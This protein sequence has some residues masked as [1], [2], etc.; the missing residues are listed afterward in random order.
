MTIRRI[1]LLAFLL[2]SLLP[3]A[4][5]T[6]LAFDRSRAAMLGEIEQGVMRSTA[7]VSAEADKLLYE[8]LLNATTWNHLE[9]MQDLRIDDVDKRLSSFLSE[10]KLRYG[11][12]Y[13][14]LHAVDGAGR[15]VA[16]SDPARIGQ[17]YPTPHPWAQ[18]ALPGGLVRVEQPSETAGS[19]VLLLR[20]SIP[21]LFEEGDIGDLLLE[22]DWTT[23]QSVMD[24]A[25]DASRQIL[26][27]DD[28]GHALGA[29][30]GLL[31]RITTG[32]TLPLG[33]WPPPPGVHAFDREG[34]PFMEGAVIVGHA[35]SPGLARFPGL[36]WSY[37]MLQSRQAVLAP[38]QRM[39]WAFAGLLAV[40]ALITV[41]V[42]LLVAGQIARPV[43][44]LTDFTR[45]YAQPGARPQLPQGG[46]AEIGELGRSFVRLVDDLSH[47]QQTLAQASKLAAVGEV[48]ALL[49]HEVRTPLGILRSSAQTL[50]YEDG[51]S[52]EAQELL[53]IIDSET[54]RLNRLVSSLLDSARTRSPQFAAVDLHAL[55]RHSTSLL[56]TQL[57]DRRIQLAMELDAANSMV[58]GDGEQLTQ[59]LLNLTMNALQILPAEGRIEIRSRNE[60]GRLVVEISDDGPGV[61][62]AERSRIFEP[63]VFKREGGLGLGLAVVRQILRQHGGDISVDESRL[64]GACFRF[65]LPLQGT[66]IP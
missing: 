64:G 49:A 55:A 29:S 38:V 8:R 2:V 60:S 53:Q 11:G 27:V 46:P 21:S 65:W 31:P 12:T 57:R 14:A 43:L 36:G 40:T 47:S 15:I 20:V 30:A 45:R 54:G 3:A 7:A 37:L 4:V 26:L 51:L 10:M 23:L 56:N 58:D 35:V 34:P 59:V 16:S 28:Q 62:A 17:A 66:R 13:R 1:L 42:S 63:F 50:R 19:R 61:A 44:A 24:R 25:S 41:L 5:L 6:R 52:P 18:A 33:W 39:A 9:V 48:T 22:F 32:K